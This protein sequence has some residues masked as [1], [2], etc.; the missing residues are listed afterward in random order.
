MTDPCGS[1]DWFKIEISSHYFV[2]K[3][4]SQMSSTIIL[5]T[6]FMYYQLAVVPFI[7]FQ[8]S[9]ER[10]KCNSRSITLLNWFEFNFEMDNK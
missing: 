5:T 2:V 7:H 10:D 9:F 1:I 6:I 4:M 3:V 8:F